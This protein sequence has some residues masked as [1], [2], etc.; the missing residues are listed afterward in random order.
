MVGEEG[1]VESFYISVVI[2]KRPMA[3]VSDI[4]KFVDSF[5]IFLSKIIDDT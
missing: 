2:A 4:E 1:V 3:V 5:A